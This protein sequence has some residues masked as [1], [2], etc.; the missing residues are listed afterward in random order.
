MALPLSS[1]L[2]LSLHRTQVDYLSSAEDVDLTRYSMR[3]KS[4]PANR[5]TLIFQLDDEKDIGSSLPRSSQNLTFSSQWRIRQ[6]LLEVGAKRIF[7]TQGSIK[8][9]H[10]L[11]N[12]NLRRDF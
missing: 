11:I 8:H 12:A 5:L 1:D 9:T 7:D 10:N 4:S 2:H 3:L 6:L